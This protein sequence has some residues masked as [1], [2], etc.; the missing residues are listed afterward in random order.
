MTHADRILAF[1]GGRP[2]HWFDDDELSAAL[3]IQ[4]RQTVN[5]V[6]RR[7]AAEGRIVRERRD[8]KVHNAALSPVNA[9]PVPHLG[10]PRRVEP[11]RPEA[12]SLLHRCADALVKRGLAQAAARLRG[13]AEAGDARQAVTSCR[14]VVER[15]LVAGGSANLAVAIDR[16]ASV[17]GADAALVRSHMHTVRVLGNE[18]VHGTAAVGWADIRVAAGAL[19]QVLAGLSY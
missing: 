19:L 10:P 15:L 9:A 1:L 17:P 3:R 2:G 16:W 12:T 5:Q 8:G 14:W 11:D 18:A 13:A 4:P 6:C 7:L